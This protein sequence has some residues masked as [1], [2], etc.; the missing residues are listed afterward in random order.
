[1]LDRGEVPPVCGMLDVVPG[2]YDAEDRPATG[3]R[4][5]RGD[6]LGEECRVPIRHTGD[7]GS[8]LDPLGDRCQSAEGDIAL[9]DGCRGPT[10][11]PQLHYVVHHP[12]RRITG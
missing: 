9:E 10:E 7:K 1:L 6:M 3:E 11:R 8:Q 4:V 2:C 5:E 12:H